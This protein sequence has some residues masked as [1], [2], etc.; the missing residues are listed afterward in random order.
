MLISSNLVL[1]LGRELALKRCRL[2][3]FRSPIKT[4]YYF[5]L[6]ATSAAARG[7]VWTLQHPLTLF[8]LVP[9]L[10]AYGSAKYTGE[11]LALRFGSR[12]RGVLSPVVIL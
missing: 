4:L 2:T 11:S 9:I 1:Q 10:A 7:A 8:M 5:T 3:F 12:W 6:S